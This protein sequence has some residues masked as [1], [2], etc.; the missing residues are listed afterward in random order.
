MNSIHILQSKQGDCLAPQ[1]DHVWCALFCGCLCVWGCR[2][3]SG[4]H[5]GIFARTCTW[6]GCQEGLVHYA[7]KD[8]SDTTAS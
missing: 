8:L 6:A 2:G 3:K 4:I 1:I 7:D 5:G